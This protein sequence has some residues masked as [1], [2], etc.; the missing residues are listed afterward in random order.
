VASFRGAALDEREEL[1]RGEVSAS[2]SGD[3]LQRGLV[4]FVEGR[5]GVAIEI[6][7]AEHLAG[8]VCNGNYQLR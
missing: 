1:G 4:R 6:E 5:F 7:H 8:L 2:I 3:F